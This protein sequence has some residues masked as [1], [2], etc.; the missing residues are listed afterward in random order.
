[1]RI[2]H[3]LVAALSGATVLIGL[4]GCPN[5]VPGADTSAS[6]APSSSTAPTSGSVHEGTISSNE[7]WTKA[8]SPH[9]VT[10]D[11]YVESAGGATLT[12]EAGA[13]VRFEAGKGLYVGWSGGTTGILKAQGT[14]TES[15]TFTSASASKAKGDWDQIYIGNGGASTIMTYAKVM[16]GGGDGELNHSVLRVSGSANKPTLRNC[17]FEN[18]NGTAIYVENEASFT[19]FENNTVKSSQKSPLQ[20]DAN[21]AGTLGAGNTFVSNGLQAIE[22][23][24]ST[25]NKNARWRNF[26]VPYL[27]LGDLYVEGSTGPV[28]TLDAGNT[29]R[30]TAGRGLYVA[31]SGGTTGALYA[32]GT[33]TERI[34]FTGIESNPNPGAWD[35]LYFGD[36]AI[37][38][39]ADNTGSCYLKYV[40]VS[41]GGEDGGT[42]KGSVR[43]YNSK[44]LFDNLV[45]N[46]SAAYGL[47]VDGD[48][49]GNIPLKATLDASVT[50]TGNASGLLRFPTF[51]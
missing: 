36:G 13:E 45:I 15:I 33:S 50:G 51:E 26:G 31:W 8:K 25:V 21:A 43:V 9:V 41:Y 7:T 14:S 34:T 30:F 47:Y 19:A 5:I 44:P 24:G 11:V 20:L 23:A 48:L 49:A 17:T 35:E 2:H 22:V 1:M 40:T 29:L 4:T 16:Y 10:G 38:G 28:L 46:Q 32:A 18:N 37:N 42:D 27:L 39:A 6:P 12:I 3:S